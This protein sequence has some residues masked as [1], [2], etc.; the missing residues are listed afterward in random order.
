[1]KRR[2]NQQALQTWIR[3]AKD[4]CRQFIIPLAVFQTIRTILL[5]TSFDVILLALFILIAIAF[6]FEWI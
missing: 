1:M 5:P 4:V 6:Y 3:T 2:F